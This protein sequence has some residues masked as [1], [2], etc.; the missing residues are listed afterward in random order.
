MDVNVRQSY[1]AL[2]LLEL[3]SGFGTYSIVRYF[4][5]SKDK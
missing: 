5:L 1:A 4:Q 3:M 2:F